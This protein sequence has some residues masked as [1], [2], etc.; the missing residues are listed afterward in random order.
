MVRFMKHTEEY[1]Q[2]MS[3]IRKEW[4]EKTKKNPVLLEQVK[5]NIGNASKGRVFPKGEDSP[6]WKGGKYTTKRDGYIFT[7]CPKHPFAKRN[8]KGG[9]GYV[10]E[11]RL[12]MEKIIGR[13]LTKEED[14]HHKNGIKDDNR[15]ENLM[16]ISHNHH[17]QVIQ[18]PKCNFQFHIQ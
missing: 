10:L 14:V 4:W 12:V 15:P 13:Y 3:Q 6:H 1:K 11:H 16:L 2:K 5:I 17:Y 18:C 9:G 8:G 7:Y